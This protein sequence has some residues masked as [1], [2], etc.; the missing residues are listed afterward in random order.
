MLVPYRT[1]P[2]SGINPESERAAAVPAPLRAAG[3][4]A[5]AG[6][7]LDPPAAGLEVGL[8]FSSVRRRVRRAASSAARRPGSP[9]RGAAPARREAGA[10]GTTKA[11][12]G[13]RLRK[14]ARPTARAREAGRLPP[15]TKSP[16]RAWAG[17]GSRRNGRPPAAESWEP[18]PGPGLL[19]RVSPL[20]WPAG[21]R[22]G[23]GARVVKG[24]GGGG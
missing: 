14:R 1:K 18:G 24:V 6:L 22:A 8:Q 15:K 2:L 5:A 16:A 17:A 9:V 12:H 20:G 10:Q 23:G 11:G 19:P 3:G 7:S 4:S 21:R 13:A